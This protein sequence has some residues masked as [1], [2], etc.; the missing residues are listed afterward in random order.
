VVITEF[1]FPTVRTATLP[2][3]AE[4]LDDHATDS[5]HKKMLGM[6]VTLCSKSQEALEISTQLSKHHVELTASIWPTGSWKMGR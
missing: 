1:H 5:N 2:H 6:A 3:W 4:M